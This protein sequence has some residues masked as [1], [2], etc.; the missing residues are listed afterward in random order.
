MLRGLA[1]GVPLNSHLLNVASLRR[2]H[3]L[4]HVR[5]RESLVDSFGLRGS[6]WKDMGL[7]PSTLSWYG[8]HTGYHA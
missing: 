7:T 8:I 4:F 6:Y 2:A 3:P 5:P 1:C